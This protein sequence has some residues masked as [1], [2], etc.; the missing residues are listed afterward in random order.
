MGGRF[1]V[2]GFAS[3]STVF[4]G[5]TKRIVNRGAATLSAPTE[6]PPFQQNPARRCR[7]VGRSRTINGNVDAIPLFPLNKG[8]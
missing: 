4:I 8:D 7:F 3:T 1:L 5:D 6:D 2:G